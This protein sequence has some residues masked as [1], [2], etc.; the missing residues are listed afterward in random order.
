M[1]VR[2]IVSVQRAAARDVI[3]DTLYYYSH[4]SRTDPC[5]NFG[6]DFETLLKQQGE[7]YD[8]WANSF[9]IAAVQCLV[10]RGEGTPEVV[11]IFTPNQRLTYAKAF[12]ENMADLR[13]RF[14]GNSLN[15][16]RLDL[17]E[18]AL[19]APRISLYLNLNLELASL[20]PGVAASST[21]LGLMSPEE[22][23]TLL[24][25]DPPDCV[26][27]AVAQL[28][29][30][31]LRAMA[32]LII[33]S[34]ILTQPDPSDEYSRAK[35]RLMEWVLNPHVIDKMGPENTQKILMQTTEN[36]THLVCWFACL[37]K[38]EVFKALFN[39]E[40]IE[41]LGGGDRAGGQAII[42]DILDKSTSD[43]Y[44]TA[45]HAMADQGPDI[46]VLFLDK[47]TVEN[48]GRE[49]VVF[50]LERQPKRAVAG[51]DKHRRSPVHVFFEFHFLNKGS[52]LLS[53][54]AMEN[55]GK[56]N[57]LN[58]LKREAGGKSTP[59]HWAALKIPFSLER[60]FQVEFFSHFGSKV[61]TELLGMQIESGETVIHLSHQIGRAHV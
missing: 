14:E 32:P 7:D 23:V 60:F 26:F 42:K 59:L 41:A 11:P 5:V 58:L 16:T 25:H 44:L 53:S 46:F 51:I 48:L 13:K 30:E 27:D 47:K 55:L 52:A 2:K 1:L 43:T 9:L 20:G 31:T 22:V 8:V 50:L 4:F 17:I 24:S 36:K 61:V 12:S 10:P 57:I 34:E 40:T 6:R 19:R 18:E 21:P 54:E 39:L 37:N 3:D 33:S 38:V 49:N 15:L 29:K 35:T 56:Q 45:V 28:P